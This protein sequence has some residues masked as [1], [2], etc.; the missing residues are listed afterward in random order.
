MGGESGRRNVNIVA[1]ERMTAVAAAHEE[2][3]F[4]TKRTTTLS[5]GEMCIQGIFFIQAFMVCNKP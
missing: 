1:V 5:K 2:R 3:P 4:S